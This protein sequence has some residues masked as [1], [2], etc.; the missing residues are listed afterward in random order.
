[1]RQ[2]ENQLAAITAQDRSSREERR[3]ISAMMASMMANMQAAGCSNCDRGCC[4]VK[5]NSIEC[6]QTA[7][8]REVRAF[9]GL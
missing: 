2:Q 6:Q 5:N 8:V 3:V 4:G 7:T 1:M 9:N